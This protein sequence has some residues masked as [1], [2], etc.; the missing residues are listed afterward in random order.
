MHQSNIYD[1]AKVVDT[2]SFTHLPGRRVELPRMLHGLEAR[3]A[4]DFI[5]ASGPVD[6]LRKVT[7]QM[8][9]EYIE[10]EMKEWLCTLQSL[11]VHQIQNLV[12]GASC[13]P[14]IKGSDLTWIAR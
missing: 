6:P 3:I 2:E 8:I 14:Y 5:A 12:I 13:R 10:T 11:P 1:E 9:D 7:G 4:L